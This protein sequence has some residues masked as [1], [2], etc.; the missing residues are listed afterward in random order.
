MS[1]KKSPN[2]VD[3]YPSG[4]ADKHGYNDSGPVFPVSRGSGLQFNPASPTYGYIEAGT[5]IA[6]KASGAGNP[7]R[8]QYKG[9][10]VYD[11]AFA[12]GDGVDINFQIPRDVVLYEAVALHVYWSHN[13]TNISGTLTMTYIYSFAKGYNQAIF[14]NEKQIELTYSTVNIATTPQYQHMTTSGALSTPGGSGTL[15]D[16]DY[17]EPG[18]MFLGRLNVSTLPTIT[19]G[20]LFIH[21]A[22][23]LCKGKGIGTYNATPSFF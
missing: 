12:S 21:S 22:N 18:A 4:S 9:G 15:I 3:L 23:L 2:S 14:A 7:T 1:W 17:V 8:T 10:S 11:W 6:P 16:Q 19:G 5:T 20:S 13:G